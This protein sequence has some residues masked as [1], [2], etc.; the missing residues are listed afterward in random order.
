MLLNFKHKRFDFGALFK[1]I[2]SSFKSINGSSLALIWLFLFD[3]NEG[4]SQ[5]KMAYEILN[6]CGILDNFVLGFKRT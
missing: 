1:S 2:I 3:T 6:L 5:S 4:P